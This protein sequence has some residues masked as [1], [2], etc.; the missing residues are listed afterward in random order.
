M[1]PVGRISHG[2]CG[3]TARRLFCAALGAPGPSVFGALDVPGVQLPTGA[4]G[5]TGALGTPGAFAGDQCMIPST[6][7]PGTPGAPHGVMKSSIV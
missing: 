2:Y 5:A 1:A 4:I 3:I 7:A 6:G